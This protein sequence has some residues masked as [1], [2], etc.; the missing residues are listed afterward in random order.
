M[1]ALRAVRRLVVAA[2]AGG[3]DRERDRDGRRARGREGGADLGGARAGIEDQREL[4]AARPRRSP[5]PRPA[6]DR[7]G[8]R[9]APVPRWR[10]RHAAGRG[11]ASRPRPRAGPAPTG[12]SRCRGSR[13]ARS[14]PAPPPPARSLRTTTEPPSPPPGGG[15]RR[16]GRRADRTHSAAPSASTAAADAA[17]LIPG[18]RSTRPRGGVATLPLGSAARV[19]YRLP[20]PA[21]HTHS[22]HPGQ[23]AVADP[24]VAVDSCSTDGSA[25][26]VRARGI[27]AIVHPWEGYGAARAVGARALDG[28]RLPDLPRLGRVP[29]AGGDRGDPPLEG[30]RRDAALRPAVDP[31][32]GR[33]ARAALPLPPRAPHPARSAAML[34][35]GSRGW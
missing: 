10:R 9:A 30:D 20:I 4:G 22:A 1:G 29:G 15:P 5:P 2:A 28:V 32:L 6:R 13:R 17:G 31:R 26:L 35:A 23:R 25:G 14:R 12:E 27:P 19:G 18:R 7:T 16:E 21:H 8:A 34:P 3:P 11:R 33:A 24:V